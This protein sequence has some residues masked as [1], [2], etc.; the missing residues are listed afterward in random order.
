MLALV[1]IFIGMG[2]KDI[3]AALWADLLKDRRP[4][5]AG[6]A[7]G[8]ADIL[9]Y[10]FV[11]ISIYDHPHRTTLWTVLAF[12]LLFAGSVIG[13][14]IGDLAEVWLQQRKEGAE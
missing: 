12:A 10:G 1:L 6:C 7:D 14:R 11:G 5:L 2:V 9:A 3:F 4:W 8:T 13:T